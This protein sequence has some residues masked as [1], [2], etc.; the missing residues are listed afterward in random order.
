[1]AG[2][3]CYVLPFW[4]PEGGPVGG[5]GNGIVV[6]AAIIE[7][8]RPVGVAVVKSAT[9]DIRE[10]FGEAS[11]VND[12]TVADVNDGTVGVVVCVVVAAAVVDIAKADRCS[13]GSIVVNPGT[14]SAREIGRIRLYFGLID[15]PFGFSAASYW[16]WYCMTRTQYR[17]YC[18]DN[19]TK[20]HV[21]QRAVDA[22]ETCVGLQKDAAKS[23]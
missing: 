17:W 20:T 9:V 8:A 12:A 7:V 10:A 23:C 1:M 13:V 15:Y 3:R 2:Q 14:V 5:I 18:T 16:G 22:V 21:S 6:T 11:V 19:N 4:D